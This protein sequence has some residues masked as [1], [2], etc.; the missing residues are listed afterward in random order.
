MCSVAMLQGKLAWQEARVAKANG[1]GLELNEDL[2]LKV[3]KW[4]ASPS[5]TA[6]ASVV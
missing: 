4:R 3:S 5:K 2:M 1:H 6:E